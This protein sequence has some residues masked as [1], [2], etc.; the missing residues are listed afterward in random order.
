M[1]LYKCR[2][3]FGACVVYSENSCSRIVDLH[4]LKRFHQS[5]N[6]EKYTLVM[7]LL[8]LDACQVHDIPLYP[9]PLSVGALASG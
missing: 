3:Y 9:I 6:P 4:Y 8:H 7:V 1:Y 2:L 5:S